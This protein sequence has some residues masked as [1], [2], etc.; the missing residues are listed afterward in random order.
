MN[1]YSSLWHPAALYQA[2]GPPRVEDAADHEQ[3]GAG[4]VYAV[5]ESPTPALADDWHQRAL[6][7]SA[8]P[9]RATPDRPTTLAHL[10]DALRLSA[11]AALLELPPEK[12]APFLGIGLGYLLLA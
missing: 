12:V 6:A 2:D 11:P 1:G 7:A 5:P 10:A 8:I 4:H 3:P 9:F